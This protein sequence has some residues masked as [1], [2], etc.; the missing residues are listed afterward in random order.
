MFETGNTKPLNINIGRIK[1]MVDIIACC[2]VEEIVEMN[3]PIPRVLSRK[4][5]VPANRSHALPLK[6]IV[7]QNIAKT[8][9]I[10]IWTWAIMI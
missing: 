7:N 8:I 5:Q 2:W 9:T 10:I 1:K 3:S 4:R 6:G